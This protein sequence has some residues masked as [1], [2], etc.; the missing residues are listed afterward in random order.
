MSKSLSRSQNKGPEWDRGDQDWE[1]RD[2]AF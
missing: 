1:I 2:V